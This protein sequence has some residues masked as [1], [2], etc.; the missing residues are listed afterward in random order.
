MFPEANRAEESTLRFEESQFS[1]LSI[2]AIDRRTK[3][4]GFLFVIIR[5]KGSLDESPNSFEREVW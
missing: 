5:C 1:Q 2:F 3:T 4:T